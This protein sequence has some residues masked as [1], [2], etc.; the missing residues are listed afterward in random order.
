MPPKRGNL[1]SEKIEE[2]EAEVCGEIPIKLFESMM[3]KLTDRMIKQMDL[4]FKN[5]LNY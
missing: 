1:S 2:N 4:L 3:D 5:I